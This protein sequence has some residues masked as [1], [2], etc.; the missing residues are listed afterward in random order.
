[1]IS[2][3]H[4]LALALDPALVMQSMAIT[5]DPWQADLLRSTSAQVL[6]NCHR[7]SGKSTVVGALGAHTAVYEPG[8]LVLLLSPSLR[9]SG[10]LFR[11]V[12]HAYRALGQPVPPASETK[13]TLE[14]A[15]GSRIVSLPGKEETVRGFSNVRLLLV[16][17]AARVPDALYYS[18]RPM[19]AV[20]G[21]RLVALSTPFGK[22]GWFYES[23]ISLSSWERYEVPVTHCPRISAQF[24]QEEREALGI[25]YPQ[26][27]ECRFLQPEGAVFDYEHIEAM[28]DPSLEPLFAAD[29]G[30]GLQYIAS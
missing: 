23:W 25:W 2:L 26:E 6:L 3:G 5:P 15:N 16:D 20:S 10:E 24:L 17:E 4:D 27:Y 18:V 29:M 13:L 11:K 30:P 8:A 19:L 22:R 7:Q 9:Q 14:L 1:M 28:L 21:G 12:L